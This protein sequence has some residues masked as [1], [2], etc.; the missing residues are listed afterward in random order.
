ME[1]DTAKHIRMLGFL[2]D[3]VAR[4]PKL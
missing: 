1:H 3:H 4:P 2:A